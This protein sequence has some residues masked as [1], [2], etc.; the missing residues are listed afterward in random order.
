MNE[1]SEHTQVSTTELA[2]VLGLTARYIRQLTEDGV[3][4]KQA[5]GRYALCDSVRR[6]L[7]T[8]KG[9]EPSSQTEEK[10]QAEIEIKRAKATVAKLEADELEGRMH[11][12][13]DVAA[14]TEDLIY[15][16]RSALL[17]LP[18]RLAVDTAAVTDAAKTAELIRREV[19]R[20]MEE[21]AGYRYDPAKYRGRVRERRNWETQGWNGEDDE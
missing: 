19:Y 11:R 12:S 7:Q 2:C 16:V 6:Y 5:R 20:V 13:E 15:A 18:G 3:L 9:R 4:E 17:A 10:L 21:L 1:I 14:M 8:L